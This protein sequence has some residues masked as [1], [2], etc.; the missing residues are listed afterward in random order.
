MYRQIASNKRKSLALLAGFLVLYGALGYVLSLWFGAAALVVALVVAVAM[1]LINLYMADDLVMAV[2]G[3][4]QIERKE[5]APA[6]WRMVEN[7]AITAG[8][9]MPRLYV[10]EDES[11][12]AFAA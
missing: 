1:L 12:N 9:P 6:L 3:A 10:V 5:E 4:R 7:L 11:P 2:A 8:L